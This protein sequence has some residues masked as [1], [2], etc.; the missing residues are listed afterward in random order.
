MVINTQHLHKLFTGIIGGFMIVVILMPS[1]IFA[2]QTD[3]TAE[4]EF[5]GTIGVPVRIENTNIKPGD[6]ISLIDGRYVLSSEA[7]DP[8]V[9]GVISNSPTLVVGNIE[10]EQVYIVVSSGI[11]LVRVSTLYGSIKTGDYITT[12]AI[13]GIGAKADKFGII[14]GTALED[15]SNPDTEIINT[16]AVNFDIGTYGLLTNIASNPRVAFR[17]VLAFVVAA[18]SVLSGFIYFGKVARSGVE[19]LGRN[20]LAARLIN[21]GV[22]FHLLLTICIMAFGIL[23]AYIIIVL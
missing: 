1:A 14:I 4:S 20:P 15:Y 16:I 8:S 9:M 6:I 5:Q 19:S 2:Q 23:I 3:S 18:A 7:Y 11:T 13:P 17:Y 22:L 12:S 10:D 21:M